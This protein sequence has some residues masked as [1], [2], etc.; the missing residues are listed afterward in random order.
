MA[1]ANSDFLTEMPNDTVYAEIILCKGAEFKGEVIESDT[2]LVEV[3]GDEIKI[4]Q[5]ELV[6]SPEIIFESNQVFCKGDTSQIKV[7]GFNA[8][9]WTTG[10]QTSAISIYEAGWYGVEVTDWYGCVQSDSIF[11]EESSVEASFDA[12]SVSCFGSEDGTIF[13]DNF[14]GSDGPFEYKMNN[15]I[16]SS[17][18]VINDLAAG[19]YKLSISNA[20]GCEVLSEVNVG[21]PERPELKISKDTIGISKGQFTA[22]EVTSYD[23]LQYFN[24]TPAMGLSCT[25]CAEPNVAVTRNTQY[26]L[27]ASDING[28]SIRDTVFVAY[29]DQL[30]IFVPNVF[31][32]NGDGDHDMFSIYGPEVA[33]QILRMNI[34]DR[35]GSIVYQANNI[36]LS[37][38]EGI[39][40]GT[41][42]GKRLPT[43]VYVVQLEVQLMDGTVEM[44]NRSVSLMP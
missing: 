16:I 33:E 34:F 31:T 8:Y 43:G 2:T 6:D 29:D 27:E 15:D 10:N 42:N 20:L 14:N 5:I 38:S 21:S 17:T 39:W 1:Y 36:L 19:N 9:K 24:W 4:Y 25:D 44:I 41:Q 28:C 40:D 11:L 30:K 22:I 7:T 23:E 32:P 35:W 13:I 12:M 3:N 37:D 18:E 26:V